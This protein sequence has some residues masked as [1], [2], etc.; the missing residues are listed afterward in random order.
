MKVLRFPCGEF[1][2]NSLF[3]PCYFVRLGTLSL[4]KLRVSV[5]LQPVGPR[6]GNPVSSYLAGDMCALHAHSGSYPRSL[7]ALS[8]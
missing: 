5:G 8:R 2:D 6:Q 3:A 4:R 1:P 7:R